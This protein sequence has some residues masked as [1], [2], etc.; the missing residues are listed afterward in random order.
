MTLTGPWTG[1]FDHLPPYTSTSQ[2]QQ[3]CCKPSPHTGHQ[4]QLHQ[5]QHHQQQ[6]RPQMQSSTIDFESMFARPNQAPKAHSMQVYRSNDQIRQCLSGRSG[7]VRVTD[8]KFIRGWAPANGSANK[9]EISLRFPPDVCPAYS[10][11]PTVM[12]RTDSTVQLTPAL[13][14]QPN[15][16]HTL[17]K[18]GAWP[19]S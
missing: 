16:P 15:P 17:R 19:D 11:A 8:Q 4:Q 2:S 14:R 5:Q 9:K 3:R 10:S 12:L 18:Y 6:H 7:S 1:R 13:D